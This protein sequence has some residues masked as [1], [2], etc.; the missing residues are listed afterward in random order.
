M[1]NYYIAPES[2]FDATADAIRAKTGSQA[3]IEWTEDGFA[4][5]IDDIQTGYTLEQI[6]VPGFSPM[7]IENVVFTGQYIRPTLFKGNTSIKSF[8]GNSVISVIGDIFGTG[9]ETRTFQ[10]CTNLESVTLPLITDFYHADYMFNGCTKLKTVNM[11]F[12]NFTRLGTGVF[13]NCPALEVT[14]MVFPKINSN[15][16]GEFITENSYLEAFDFE[17]SGN[18]HGNSINAN[19]FKND[20]NLSV[21]V[22]RQTGRIITLANISAF[23]GTPFASNG[24][25]G[26]LYV[27]N[28]LIASYQSAT[29]WSTILEYTNN[30]I[31]SIESTHT[32]QT[33]PIDLTLYYADGTLIE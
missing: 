30:K 4:D 13:R 3:S 17:K 31:K 15:V 26:T 27:P 10:D 19:A 2:S 12:K 20:S 29:N 33:A 18:N 7:T 6:S 21:V 25:G 32:D 14:V 28:D 8:V 24:T 16:Y 5:A 9:A 22:I 23:S 1:A 11:N